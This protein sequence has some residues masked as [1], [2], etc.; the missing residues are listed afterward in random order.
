MSD[1]K[2]AT[3]QLDRVTTA[4]ALRALAIGIE[5]LSDERTEALLARI[6][7]HVQAIQRALEDVTKQ[8]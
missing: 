1:L 7:A 5:E 8:P 2:S 4:E 6:R 3:L